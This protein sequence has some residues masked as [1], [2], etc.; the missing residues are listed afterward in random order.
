[1]AGA[2]L[3]TDRNTDRADTSLELTTSPVPNTRIQLFEQEH[4]ISEH[5]QKKKSYALVLQ[6][7]GEEKCRL[8][9]GYKGW[10]QWGGATLCNRKSGN[11]EKEATLKR[12]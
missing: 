6:K 8:E 3:S 2:A 1:M 5:K 11:E 10:G 9:R 4:G 12:Q 7:D